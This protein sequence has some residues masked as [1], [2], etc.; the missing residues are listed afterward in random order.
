MPPYVASRE[1][2]GFEEPTTTKRPTTIETTPVTETTKVIKTTVN[3]ITITEETTAEEKST[4]SVEVTSAR[5]AR[6]TGDEENERTSIV[7]SSIEGSGQS[8]EVEDHHVKKQL[9]DPPEDFNTTSTLSPSKE[10]MSEE[11]IL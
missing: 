10:L 9:T 11:L 1:D 2:N 7:D 6:E 8:E 3:E 4:E 5:P